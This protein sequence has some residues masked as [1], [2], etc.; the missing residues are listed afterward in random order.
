MDYFLT[1]SATNAD[2][3]GQFAVRLARFFRDDVDRAARRAGQK[4]F[5]LPG[6]PARPARVLDMG[7]GRG[8]FVELFE[9]FGLVAIGIDGDPIVSPHAAEEQPR[10]GPHRAS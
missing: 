1:A 4:I 3:D 2:F 8:S 5:R 10:L 6:Q 9:R 7:C